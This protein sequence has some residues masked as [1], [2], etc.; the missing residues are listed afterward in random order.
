[1]GINR[2]RL[3]PKRTV[4]VF[5]ALVIGITAAFSVA[6]PANAHE[7]ARFRKERRH[8]KKRAMKQIGTPY[9]YGGTSPN[10]FDCSGLTSWTFNG[11]AGTLP[12]RA[13]DQ[14]YLAKRPR[15]KRV[16]RRSHLR[17]GDLVFHKTTSAR[18]GHAG[19]YIGHG[20]FLST[21]S[22]GGV[23]AQSLR[24]PYYW[25]PRWVGATRVPA[26]RKRFG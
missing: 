22:S 15:F 14:F 20:K 25:G 9:V 24:D 17:K 13:I 26:T 7:L 21:T 6:P 18:V 1:M 10:G 16:W 5:I 2:T 4:S 23:R 12:R 3:Q 19:I 11:H 8:L